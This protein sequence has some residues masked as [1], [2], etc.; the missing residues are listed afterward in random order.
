MS[1]MV[2]SRLLRDNPGWSLPW[3]PTLILAGG[4]AI[5]VIL[6]AN[7]ELTLVALPLLLLAL[8]LSERRYSPSF[9]AHRSIAIFRI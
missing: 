1:G 6:E 3:T 2:V 9:L 5:G 4:L 8:I 7:H